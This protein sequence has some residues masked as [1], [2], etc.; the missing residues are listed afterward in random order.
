MQ[1]IILA[2]GLGTR[3]QSE[4]SGMPKAMANVAGAPFLAWLLEYA[5]GQGVSEV[6]L[7]VGHKAEA[8]QNY[9]GLRFAGIN[10]Q[11]SVEK[12]QLGTGGALAQ[13]L[14]LANPHAPC[15]VMNGDSLVMLDYAKMLRA[16]VASDKV[17]TLATR[18]MP[19]TE[20]YSKLTLKND[21][22]TN[23]A[24]LGDANAGE[25][26][27]GFYVVNPELFSDYDLPKSFSFERDF[28]SLQTPQLLPAAYNE[29]KYFIDIGVPVDYARAQS[30]IPS[31]LALKVAA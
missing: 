17:I 9:F 20:R 7:A 24:L 4:L 19:T 3:L 16:H 28:L 31:R 13:A 18:H 11:Y 25:V 29:V 22:I 15:L 26:S 1:A 8:I 6:V 23:Y 14:T 10:I 12:E 27:V 21:M 2:G 5:A 30:E